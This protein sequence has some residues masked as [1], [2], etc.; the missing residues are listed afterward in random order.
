MKEELEDKLALERNK[1]HKAKVEY[2]DRVE[3]LCDQHEVFCS[4]FD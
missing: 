2:E 1:S 4:K 3:K